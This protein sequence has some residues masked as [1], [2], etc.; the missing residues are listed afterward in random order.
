VVREDAAKAARFHDPEHRRRRVGERSEFSPQG[1]KYEVLRADEETRQGV[2][3]G[4]AE[5]DGSPR[6][7]GGRAEQRAVVRVAADDA[8][9]HDD[10]AASTASGSAAMSCI[11]HSTRPSRPCSASN[12]LAS[13]SYAGECSR[14]TARA[15]PRFSSSISISPTPPPISSTVAPSMPCA[16]RNATIRRPVVETLRPV[17]A[18]EAGGEARSEELVAPA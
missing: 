18:R 5:H 17:P 13:S 4:E 9:E 1:A 3:R 7:V 16:A 2:A 15:A 8:V 11:R 14:F 12:R 10:S 6:V